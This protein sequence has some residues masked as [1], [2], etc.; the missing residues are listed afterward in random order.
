MAMTLPLGQRPRNV[1][2][3]KLPREEFA[4]LADDLTPVEFDIRQVLYEPNQPMRHAYFPESGMVSIVSLMENGD[5]IEVGT[6]GREGVVGAVLLLEADEV[7]YRSY[8]QMMGH[9][10]RMDAGRFVKHAARAPEFRRLV[11]RYHA[12]FVTHTMQHVACNGLHTVQQRCCRWLLMARDRADSD[13]IALTHEFL[14]IMLGVRRASVTDVLRPLHEAELVSSIR[15][16]IKILNRTGLEASSC[17]C[18]RAIVDQL[19]RMLA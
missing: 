13:E 18:Y 14:S 9:G 12:A 3:S 7:P 15:G 2:L 17:E 19:N 10:Y 6:I 8:V 4:S 1:L 16:K 5:S 11:L